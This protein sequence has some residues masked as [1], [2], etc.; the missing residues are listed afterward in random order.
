MQPTRWED[1][2]PRG[3]GAFRFEVGANTVLP[4]QAVVA[5]RK[6]ERELGE[7]AAAVSK[8]VKLHD[9]GKASDATDRTKAIG[10][11]RC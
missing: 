8:T 2:D 5:L 3:A 4:D 11:H 9:L 10:R 7:A 6:A 1:G